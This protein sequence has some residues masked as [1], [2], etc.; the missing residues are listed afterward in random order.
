[1]VKFVEVTND[2]E[3]NSRLERTAQLQFSLNEVWINEKYVVSFRTAPGYKKLLSE[4]RLPEDLDMSH[5]FTAILTNNG[6][7]NE[8]HVVV[9][10]TD[11]IARR[12]KVEK[13]SLLKG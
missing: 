4:G 13:R 9:G 10:D 11:T 6:N 5:E 12:L 8:T 3:F 7:I 1:M 2:T